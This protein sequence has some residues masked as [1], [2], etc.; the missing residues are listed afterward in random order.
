M[1]IPCKH[2]SQN[3]KPILRLPHLRLLRWR[4]RRLECFLTGEKISFYRNALGYLLKCKKEIWLD[5]NPGVLFV[6]R[7]WSP[8][9]QNLLHDSVHF[10]FR[11]CFHSVLLL[12]YLIDC[13]IFFKSI[14]D[15]RHLLH[16]LLCASQ[17]L[18]R[19]VKAFFLQ[20]SWHKRSSF[21]C[22]INVGWEHNLPA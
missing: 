4:C 17:V 12:C 15:L 1:M 11:F 21:L 9:R 2:I 18:G 6:R 14:S 22:L 10:R 7:M 13:L 5:S 3:K 20:G 16:S 8:F 19:Y